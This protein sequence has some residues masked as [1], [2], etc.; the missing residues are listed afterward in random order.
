MNNV[1]GNVGN[2]VNQGVG[3]VSKN[4]VE[5]GRGAGKAAL[6]IGVVRSSLLHNAP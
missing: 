3:K 2:A 4:V 6:G 5:V 1:V